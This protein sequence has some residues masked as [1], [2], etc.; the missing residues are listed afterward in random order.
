MCHTP[1]AGYLSPVRLIQTDSLV[2]HVF[3]YRETSRIVR[4]ATRSV[5]IVSVVAR[6]AR[7]PRTRFSPGLD[8]FASGVAHL[9]LH[10]TRDLHTMNGFDLAA[11]RPELAES[12][13]RFMAASV[14]SELCLRFGREDESGRVFG[15]ATALLDEIRRAADERVAGLALGGAWRLAAELGFAPVLDACASCHAPLQE[16]GPVTF[17]HHTGGALCGACSRL[18]PGGRALPPA[19]RRA[20]GDWLAGIPAD[21][22][23]A[24]SIR[25]HQRL[26]REFLEEHLGDGHPLRAFSAWEEWLAPPREVARP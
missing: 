17:Q 16:D 24:A 26:L 10:P 20:L 5:G 14:V 21:P 23:D 9:A 11:A 4:L 7:R 2:L 13:A 19:A 12:I 3:D 6:G 1:A 8:L 22:M 18:H 15:A 25:A